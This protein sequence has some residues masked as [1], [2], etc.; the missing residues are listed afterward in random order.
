MLC[1]RFLKANFLS[2]RK[3]KENNGYEPQ[4]QILEDF[5]HFKININMYNII[6]DHNN[7]YTT[8]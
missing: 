6:I 7:T 8:Q 1:T 5:V 2:R 4:I 3:Y